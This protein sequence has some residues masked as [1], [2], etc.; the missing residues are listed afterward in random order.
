MI[1]LI[2]VMSMADPFGYEPLPACLDYQAFVFRLGAVEANRWDLIVSGLCALGRVERAHLGVVYV[3]ADWG[4]LVLPPPGFPELRV[5]FY[6][7]VAG[8]RVAALL[9]R[10]SSILDGVSTQGDPGAKAAC[11][12]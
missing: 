9:G 10:I 4:F 8:E 1:P 7:R 3:R 2:V 6:R 11:G 5:S 12:S